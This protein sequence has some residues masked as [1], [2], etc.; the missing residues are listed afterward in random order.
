MKTLT[1]RTTVLA[2]VAF[3]VPLVMGM[4][5]APATA[6]NEVRRYNETNTVSLRGVTV[7]PKFTN[8]IGQDYYDTEAWQ[9][10]EKTALR[11]LASGNFVEFDDAED[12]IAWLFD[13]E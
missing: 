12:L 6:H 8:G 2:S 4:S 9:T 5:A 7:S 13:D 3:S 11:E 10:N 1:N